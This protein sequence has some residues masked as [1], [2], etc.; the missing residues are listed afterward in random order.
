M[1]ATIRDVKG[2]GNFAV[3]IRFRNDVTNYWNFVTQQWAALETSDCR[4]FLI[5][6]PDAST[7]ESRY[8]LEL[9]TNTIPPGSFL[10]EYVHASDEMVIG[11]ETYAGLPPPITGTGANL[12]TVVAQDAAAAPLEGVLV[13]AW[14]SG[15]LLAAV[16][17][18][19]T[20]HAALGMPAGSITLVL[21]K[22]SWGSF[23]PYTMTVVPGPQT[24][25]IQGT[26]NPPGPIE[27]A[28]YGVL[29]VV[30]DADSRL[31]QGYSTIEIQSS[32]DES[33]TWQAR[34]ATVPASPLQPHIM[35]MPATYAYSFVDAQGTPNRRYR[36]RYSAN[37]AAPFS[38]YF[39]WV[40]GTQRVSTAPISVGTMRFVGV[41]GMVRP[42]ALLVAGLDASAGGL[43]FVGTMLVYKTDDSGFLAIPLVQGSRVR[44]AIEGTGVVRDI[45]VPSTPAFD[46]MQAITAAPDMFTVQTVPPMLTKRSL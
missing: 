42:G 7:V 26:S 45:V 19:I 40:Y 4:R 17:T 20:G 2:L 5:E 32:D 13:Q 36:W 1:I 6:Y 37:G 10:V 16:L 31:A 24:V 38:P 29:V 44:V 18:D 43:V 23:P 41:D 3:Y 21:T 22:T 8:Q 35:L 27:L 28:G 12:V 11:E 33:A 30:G 25:V 46:I 9:A 14:Q 39:K 15:S 34:T